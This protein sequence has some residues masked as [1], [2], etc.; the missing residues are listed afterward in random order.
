MEYVFLVGV[1]GGVPH[2]TDYAK[3]VRLGDVVVS[4]PAP[5]LPDKWDNSTYY[6]SVVSMIETLT[7]ICI[8]FSYASIPARRRYLKLHK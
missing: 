7:Q 4:T 1:G 3:H 8:R 6:L 2:Y 5:D